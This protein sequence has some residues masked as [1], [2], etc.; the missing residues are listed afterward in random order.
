MCE[1][2]DTG[3]IIKI[4][5]WSWEI[6]SLRKEKPRVGSLRIG[7]WEMRSMPWRPSSVSNSSNCIRSTIATS[8]NA[9]KKILLSAW[10]SSSAV[11]SISHIFLTT[12][13]TQTNN[14]SRKSSRNIF[15]RHK[16]MLLLLDSSHKKIS[17][18][19]K[20]MRLSRRKSWDLI[21]LLL[22]TQKK[23]QLTKNKSIFYSIRSPLAKSPCKVKSISTL[24]LRK[25]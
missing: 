7:S 21:R 17:S 8:V 11:K 3:K 12:K 25:A 4:W 5:G 9:S 10:T 20:Y 1:R 19:R 24:R 18:I 14:T 16:E 13:K 23:W 2:R 22:I 6:F 15:R